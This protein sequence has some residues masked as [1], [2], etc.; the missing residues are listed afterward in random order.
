[1]GYPHAVL[2]HTLDLLKSRE[3]Q[4]EREPGAGAKRERETE[5][6]KSNFSVGSSV[7]PAL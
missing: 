5:A 2:S 4:K 3:T 1:M 7:P 6:E